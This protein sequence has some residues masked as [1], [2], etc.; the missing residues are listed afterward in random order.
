MLRRYWE[1]TE[2]GRSVPPMAV[3]RAGL[4]KPGRFLHSLRSIGMAGKG[5]CGRKGGGARWNDKAGSGGMKTRRVVKTMEGVVE[6]TGRAGL[7]QKASDHWRGAWRTRGISTEV[8]ALAE[9]QQRTEARVD[10]LAK[11]VRHLAEAQKGTEEAVRKLAKG[12]RETWQMV[13][14][15]SDTVGYVLED[16]AIR[17]LPDILVE[18][19]TKEKPVGSSR[20]TER[21]SCSCSSPWHLCGQL[22][23]SPAFERSSGWSGSGME[24]DAAASP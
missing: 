23:A 7:A 15:L 12:L 11:A 21:L 22:R 18:R 4:D 6:M 13:G 2:R 24:A 16:R 14:G 8:V 17:H 10:N 19:E 20:S 1:E 3:E 9:A 5:R